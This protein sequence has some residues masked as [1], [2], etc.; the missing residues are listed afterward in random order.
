[1]WT[2]AW[3]AFAAALALFACTSTPPTTE[4]TLGKGTSEMKSAIQ[5]AVADPGR[6]DKLLAHADGIEE[7][8]RRHAADYGKFVDEY[9]RLNDAYDTTQQQVE[10]LF[11]R[12]EQRRKD[13]RARVLELH[14][15]MIRLTSAQEWA[16]IGKVEAEMLQATI[17]V[18][19]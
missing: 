16:P 6:R 7:A 17:A 14:F 19:R 4:A 1:M 12:F 15:Q 9:R 3:L 11:A 8:L 18:P 5:R 10:A 2:S 13:S